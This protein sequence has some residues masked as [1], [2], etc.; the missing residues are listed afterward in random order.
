MLKGYYFI[1]DSRLSRAGDISDIKSALAA[2][3]KIIQYRDKGSDT[4]KM[5]REAL[6]IRQ[7]CKKALFLINDRLDIALAVNADGVH[8]GNKDMPYEVARKVL[9]KNKIIGLT[10]HSEK[11]AVLAQKQGAD[12]IGVSPIFSTKTKSDAGPGRGVGLLKAIRKKV[13]LPII[14]IGG[15]NLSNAK[16]V[17]AAG[18][19]GLC[20]IS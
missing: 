13:S 11:E 20:A 6:K 4:K 19:D 16:E 17:V 15:I 7:I 2:G 10:V 8:L 14:A 18:A 9:G 3:V 12:Y 1:T 5:Y